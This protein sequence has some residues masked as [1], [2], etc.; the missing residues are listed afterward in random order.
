M[1]VLKGPVVG[2]VVQVDQRVNFTKQVQSG[3]WYPWSNVWYVDGVNGSDNYT[4]RGP[5]DSKATIQAAVSAA[6]VRD[7][8]YVNPQTYV[9]GTG[10]ARYEERVTVPLALSDLS[11]IGAGYQRNNEFG[12]RMKAD[13]TTLFCFDI[14]GPSCHLENIGFFNEDGTNT[15]IAR[16]DGT[17]DQRGSDGFVA[18]NCN[19]KGTPT[20]IQ[21]GQAGRFIE[22]VF[23]NDTGGLVFAASAASGYNQQVRD[24]AFLGQ[25]G[26]AP[27]HP[28]L[29]SG[30]GNVYN[31]W[32]DHCSFDL[33]PTT[34]AYYI[35]LDAAQSTGM[36]TG[37]FFN[38]TNLDTDTD[39]DIASSSFILAGCYDKTGLV[40]ETND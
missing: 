19:F 25:N 33:V 5:A 16:N 20:L 34:T 28:Y 2:G 10:H 9:I 27:T 14:Y 38:T 37:S 17:T 18:Y 1:G 13:G 8:I 6:S 4:G 30:G 40:D 15:I 7:I 21:G 11:V 12:V 35:Q 31:L 29:Q 39:I 22:C 36:I 3:L 24:C 23:N 26:T 32:V